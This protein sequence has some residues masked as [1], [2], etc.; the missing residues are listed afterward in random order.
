MSY[1]LFKDYVNSI[2]SAISTIAGVGDLIGKGTQLLLYAIKKGLKTIKVAGTTYTVKG[3]AEFVYTKIKGAIGEIQK[4]L[5]W[6]D[7]KTGGTEFTDTWKAEIMPPVKSAMNAAEQ[8]S[9]A[10]KNTLFEKNSNEIDPFDSKIKDFVQE[11]LNNPDK[12]IMFRKGYEVSLSD[13]VH[14][15][16]DLKEYMEEWMDQKVAHFLSKLEESGIEIPEDEFGPRQSKFSIV[17]R[18]IY[19]TARSIDEYLDF[20]DNNLEINDYT[21]LVKA[22]WYYLRDYQ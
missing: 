7:G 21:Y 19:D 17:I 5:K 9:A 16:H 2:L 13:L 11:E 18:E 8:K 4:V 14:D 20:N 12:K 3:L 6:L 10:F 22:F 15:E 1:D